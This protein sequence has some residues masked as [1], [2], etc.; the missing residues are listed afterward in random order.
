MLHAWLMVAMWA[1]Q[2]DQVGGRLADGR[3]VAGW[4]M[5]GRWLAGWLIVGR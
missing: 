4:L 1:L 5:V 2:L 3:L